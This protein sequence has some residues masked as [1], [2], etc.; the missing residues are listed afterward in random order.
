V[1]DPRKLVEDLE[2]YEQDGGVVLW[3]KDALEK[4][5]VLNAKVRFIHADLFAKR[6]NPQETTAALKGVTAEI[7]ALLAEVQKGHH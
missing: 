5:A 6:K 3:P 4:L 1:E 7:T 2:E